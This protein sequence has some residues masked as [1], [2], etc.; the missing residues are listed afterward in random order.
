M[1]QHAPNASLISVLF[2]NDSKTNKIIGKQA[3][4]IWIHFGFRKTIYLEKN[5]LPS[6]IIEIPARRSGRFFL[7]KKW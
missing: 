2:Y 4:V 6:V 3:S 1:M 7:K 5:I